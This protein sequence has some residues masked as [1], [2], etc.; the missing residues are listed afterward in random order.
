MRAPFLLVLAACSIVNDPDRHR[1]SAAADAGL[2]PLA[3]DE[4]CAE[5]AGVICSAYDSCCPMGTETPAQCEARMLMNCRQSVERYVFDP[6]TGYDPTRGAELV[7]EARD[8][9]SRCD[10]AVAEFFAY[11]LL[12]ALQ[13]TNPRGDVCITLQQA[14]MGDFAGLFSCRRADD[15][16]CRPVGAPL[17]DWTCQG[18]SAEGGACNNLIHCERGLFCMG[19]SVFATGRC[20]PQLRNGAACMEGG[21]CQ[22]LNCVMSTCQPVD[23]SIYCTD[24]FPASDARM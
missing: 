16:V 12:T 1:E 11:D 15:L 4:A 24:L 21:E 13:G 7:A 9:A 8:L 18:T 22:S 23:T 14:G 17:G 5:L 3:P 6:R 2:T 10:P 20:M 19:G